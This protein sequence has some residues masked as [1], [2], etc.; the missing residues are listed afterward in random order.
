MS[1]AAGRG[2]GRRPPPALEDAPATIKPALCWWGFPVLQ[3]EVHWATLSSCLKNLDFL[4]AGQEELGVWRWAVNIC[5][6]TACCL[7][8]IKWH[9]LSERFQTKH[10]FLCSKRQAFVLSQPKLSI[11]FSFSCLLL[12]LLFQIPHLADVFS[13]QRSVSFS[14]LLQEHLRDT[15]YMAALLTTQVGL[16]RRRVRCLTAVVG[17]EGVGGCR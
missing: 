7:K 17:R 6:H 15:F 14:M 5:M 2:K 12:F 13:T 10:N 16:C 8:V 1:R 9:A 4:L 3:D 11:H